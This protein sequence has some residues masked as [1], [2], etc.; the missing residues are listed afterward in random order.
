[1][2]KT[3]LA[4]GIVIGS[5]IGITAASYMNNN[6]SRTMKRIKKDSRGVMEQVIDLVGEFKHMM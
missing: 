5:I 2:R 3:G 1:M 4:K 6:G